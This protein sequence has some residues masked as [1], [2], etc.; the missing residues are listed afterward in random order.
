MSGCDAFG[1]CDDVCLL[2]FA[3]AASRV[4][5]ISS[6]GYCAFLAGPPLIG[7]LGEHV[8]VLRA[9]LFGAVL[10]ALAAV[11][12]PACAGRLGDRRAAWPRCQRHR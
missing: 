2:A 6:I 11:I 3:R 8:T 12:A 10:L 9:L 1:R 4:S 7:F 5:V